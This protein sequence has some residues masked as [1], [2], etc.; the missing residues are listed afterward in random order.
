MILHCSLRQRKWLLLQPP[1]C[2]AF[3]G[4]RATARSNSCFDG[5]V[6]LSLS[7]KLCVAYARVNMFAPDAAE[8]LKELT[9]NDPVVEAAAAAPEN[10]T[11]EVAADEPAQAPGALF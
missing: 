2:M 1:P 7:Q 5:D 10:A 11:E 3:S 8:R 6:F 9:K 4:L